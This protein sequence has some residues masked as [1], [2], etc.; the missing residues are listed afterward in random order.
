MRLLCDQAHY[1]HNKMRCCACC[2]PSPIAREP[3]ANSEMTPRGRR[4][5]CGVGHSIAQP[6][7][8]CTSTPHVDTPISRRQVSVHSGGGEISFFGSEKHGDINAWLA[9]HTV[10]S[11]CAQPPSPELPLSTSDEGSARGNSCV[12]PSP[13]EAL[14][15]ARGALHRKARKVQCHRRPPTAVR[16]QC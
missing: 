15:V 4:A 9:R 10:P 8:L 2:F 5:N 1:P 12:V 14:V 16:P 6:Q 7:V 13:S 3:L 11:P